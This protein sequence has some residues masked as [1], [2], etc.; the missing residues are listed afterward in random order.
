[1]R[2][3]PGKSG[4][5]GAQQSAHPEP[6]P[7]T[8]YTR[9]KSIPRG[10]H[11]E[12]DGL[13]RRF[14]EEHDIQRRCSNI[15]RTAERYLE[16]VEHPRF[17][18]G[19]R[20]KEVIPTDVELAFYTGRLEKSSP[21]ESH[22]RH[23]LSIGASEMQYDL[24]VDGT[25]LEGESLPL[26]SLQIVNHSCTPNCTTKS[27]ESACTL[28]L[29]ILQ[30]SREI[31][32]GEHVSFNYGG[33]FWCP[34][35][36][37][38]TQKRR[39][40]KLVKCQCANPCPN[41]YARFEKA[42]PSR[43]GEAPT[44]PSQ[45]VNKRSRQ[46]ETSSESASILS[47]FSAISKEPVDIMQ[48][49]GGSMD[50]SW[51][52][53][54]LS[55]TARH[56]A[57]P[58]ESLNPTTDQPGSPP[59]RTTHSPPCPH[60][61]PPQHTHHPQDTL[62]PHPPN[63]ALSRSHQ[64]PPPPPVLNDALPSALAAV[65]TAHIITLNVGPC[66]LA[67]TFASLG[68]IL[69]LRPVAVLVQEAHVPVGRLQAVRRQIHRHFPAYS[70][71]AN[72][73]TQ[74]LSG[75]M[76]VITL[77]HVKMAAR[78]SLLDIR[79]QFQSV[80]EQAPDALDKVHF[81]RLSDPAG[82][83]TILLG[84]VHNYQA[85]Q[86]LRQ[87]AMLELIRQVVAR[88]AP[89]SNHVLIGGDWNATLRTR[90]GYVA[91][92]K[93]EAADARLVAW[94][95]AVGWNYVAPSEHTW[96][97]TSGRKRATLDAFLATD[98]GSLSEATCVETVDPRHDHR[99][100]RVI[101]RDEG[102]GP[103]PEL[104]SLC[105][106]VRLKLTGLRDA[107]IRERFRKR[108]DE[109]VLLV[110]QEAQ[111]GCCAFERL[112]RLQ[113]AV[114]KAAKTT[115][116]TSGGRIR[117]LVPKQSV[118]FRKLAA[119]IRLLRV[120]CAEL[121]R[122][123]E[124]GATPPS[125]AMCKAWHQCQEVYPGGTS[126]Q[127]LGALAANG[128]WSRR[129]VAGLRAHIHNAEEELHQLRRRESR[130]DMAR[131]RQAEID[132]F[133]SGGGLQRFLH[134][135]TPAL[136]S[137][138]LLAT[139]V[140][141]VTVEGEAPRLR[142][143]AEDPQLQ[144]L[145]VRMV[146]ARQDRLVASITSTVQLNALL[147]AVERVQA[148]VTVLDGGPR[149]IADRME[150]IAQWERF[151]GT[152]AGAT[153]QQCRECNSTHLIYVPGLTK[154]GRWWCSECSHFSTPVVEKS[155]YSRIPFDTASIAR[156]PAGATLRGPITRE[157]FDWYL[158]TLRTGR[159][160]G[161]D[162]SPN[163]LLIFGPEVQRQSL[164][165]CINAILAEGK[166][167][168]AEWLGGL[169]R[170][171]PKPGGNPLVSS[172]YRPVCLQAAVYKVLSAIITDRLYRLSE[173]H[174]LLEGSQEGF[175]RKRSTQ[176][177]VQ[178][179]HWA[180][181]EAAQ[182]GASLYVAYLDFEHAFNSVDHEAVWRWLEELNVP[183][184]DLL[185]SLYEGAHYEADLPYGRSAPV[186]LTRGTKQG[187][188]LSPLLFGLF[189]NA[190]LIGL[191]QSGV[192]HRLINGQQTTNRGFADDVALTTATQAGMQKLLDVVS[193]FCSWSGMRLKLEKSV[194]TAFDFGRRQA[195]PTE[196]I[197]YRGSAL[198]SLPPDRSFRYLGVKTALTNGRK[199]RTASGP[200]TA[201]EIQHVQQSTKELTLLLADHN[202]PL[203]VIVPAMR[204]VAASRFRYSAALVPW[205]DAALEKLFKVWMQVERAA[206][207]L[208]RSFPSA[209]FRLP[210]EMGGMPLEDP[211]V[212][213]IQALATHVRQLVALPDSIRD[214]TVKRYR[215]LCTS[216]G[217]LNERELAQYLAKEPDGE[218]RTDP[219]ARLLRACGQLGMHIKLPD[220]LSAGKA[221]REVSWF[222]FRVHLENKITAEDETGQRD[223]RCV[224]YHWSTIRKRFRARGIHFPRQ[225][226]LDPWA[227]TAQ[228][229]IPEQMT[230]QPGWLKPLRRLVLRADV[231]SLFHRLDRG[232]GAPIQAAH[233]ELLSELLRRS[234]G[235]DALQQRQPPA[236][237]SDARWAQVRSSAP[238]ECWVR[239]LERRQI[240]RPAVLAGV[241]RGQAVVKMLTD[242]GREFRR[243]SEVLRAICL[244]VAPT[245]YTVAQGRDM[246]HEED[247]FSAHIPLSRDFVILDSG[248]GRV[249]IEMERQ[250]EEF[251]V[252]T[253]KGV[254]QIE[255]A[256]GGHTATV[257]QGRYRLLAGVYDEIEVI[258]AL[259]GWIAR[260]ER[261]EKTRGV[262]SHQLWH[263]ICR[264][265]K[266]D[267]I[268]GCNPLVAPSCFT[269]ALSGGAEEGWGHRQPQTRRVFNLLCMTAPE[270]MA[271]ASS[272]RREDA[273]LALSRARTLTAEAERSLRRVGAPVHVW[274][275]GTV[276][277]A[278]TG[279]WRRAQVRSIR[280]RE[281]W[282]LWADA[283]TA[284][285]SGSELRQALRNISL[286]SDGAV[287][288]DVDCPSFR[289]AVLG[290]AG[291]S[292]S[293][294][295]TIIATDGAV[296][297][298]G[299]MGAAYVALSNRIPARSFVVLGPPS[300]MRAELSGLDQAIADAPAQE[301]LT[302]LTDSASSIKKLMHMQRRDFAE[303]LYDHP[304]G[305]LLSSIARRV[306]ERAQGRVMTRFVKVPA[307]KA[308]A[309]NEAAD[310][311][312]SAA[313]T[314]AD[315]ETVALCHADCRTVRFYVGEKLTEWGS[316]VRK[317][318]ISVASQQY[319]NQLR[320]SM[321]QQDNNHREESSLTARWLLRPAQG[322]A[323]LGAAMAGMRIGA[324]KRRLMQSIARLF[325][326]RALL[327]RWG[328]A[329]SAECLLCGGA[330]E[331]TAHIQCWCP[332]LK[333]ARIL[334][335]HAIA[336]VI[337]QLLTEHT[338][339]RWQLY[340]ETPVY[341]LRAIATPQDLH[342]MWNRMVDA[343]ESDGSDEDR[344]DEDGQQI[345]RLRP[346]GWAISWSRRQVLI[347]E[348]TRAHDWQEDWHTITDRNKTLRYTR[349]Q[350]LMRASLP[351]GWIVEII[352]LTL[353]IR[354][355][356]DEGRW[357]QILDRFGITK[358]D[359]QRRFM[360]GV[361]RQ[362][363]D[364]LD[365]LYGVRSEALRKLQR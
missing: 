131:Q 144:D 3:R 285:L 348:L 100:V 227:G 111:N 173:R 220:C 267:T 248:V 349:L 167:P 317:A 311:L 358:A 142:L 153:R 216:C 205:S 330:V 350:E 273:W 18:L 256:A 249:E 19:Y 244:W 89:Q 201:D 36:S 292:L 302:L 274:P 278:G 276:A 37:L 233:Q 86:P 146:S 7:I 24:L 223:L 352:T 230:K 64:P 177:Q 326:S 236:L 239:F 178:S 121:L 127:E 103:M 30:S 254:V 123:R 48:Q 237:F 286:S 283:K 69:A 340:A 344:A 313:A 154:P 120:V 335:H 275:K 155:A 202:L 105:K 303:W 75:K 218:F 252:R 136:H 355:S 321:N 61:S 47:Y 357:A 191:R 164:Y 231:R 308:H 307:H 140:D 73:K 219:I 225:L 1:M 172:S 51:Q 342:D 60:S 125:R 174:G 272:V 11:D 186:T 175:R 138:V 141:T 5:T 364:E 203:S 343:L 295:G 195:L 171:L 354:G 347:L 269:V 88:W 361:T 299:S 132:A 74:A 96:E 253:G 224:R 360:G 79:T 238:M 207:K 169:V 188:I 28:E 206:W 222:A 32:K 63:T 229:L 80:C 309:L 212:V 42:Q 290:P 204:M 126:F 15:R 91:G 93:T 46:T 338:A 170:F 45:P 22:R 265:F 119:W 166:A 296:K 129:A 314:E 159:A 57:L 183:D 298:D 213:L 362:V 294:P 315:G 14:H 336:R 365:R 318:L 263:G 148:L 147:T 217:C 261:E 208:Q 161:P 41:D 234:D 97:D 251:T 65:K 9:G 107:E 198:A 180:I 77:V 240:S 271:I 291:E 277:A 2:K 95:Q 245:L 316:R 152:A 165:E 102:V 25:P 259:P 257:N 353:G 156:V 31:R 341:A 190:L 363:L 289:E 297:E 246:E 255:G 53:A 118:A 117:P 137:P 200:C 115:L 4:L 324:Q 40:F 39:G 92:S 356:F 209:Q 151:L 38:I 332:A 113:A 62:I 56:I 67:E 116:G 160:P 139:L 130:E 27:I 163:E 258:R 320:M 13:I 319:A 54:S 76:D 181:E 85:D 94:T 110:A 226:V 84:N 185:R 33:S 322:R 150:R 221:A 149:Y 304:D 68:P 301:D 70:L 310:A 266:A 12:I 359:N 128:E 98:A 346:D 243:H 90:V 228:W 10:D 333:D 189:F 284:A 44:R 162:Q 334:A 168:P 82:Q 23:V 101:L 211:R 122:R 59:P 182:S 287:P 108:A 52:S 339:G 66:G 247:A 351:Q 197:R 71:F 133:W 124:E 158:T 29:T 35:R 20:A 312:A 325:P 328:K 193:D 293:Y 306:N 329:P 50:S 16:E 345:N 135:P 81:L 194:I 280:I 21:A 241:S 49:E 337:F 232:M 6:G 214:A 179:L 264:A 78:A 327:H 300:V 270:I 250:V 323:H 87:A 242:I 99:G 192:G 72:R 176:R 184:V 43:S 268:W 260:V 134:P 305:V 331:S 210:S 199:R 104:E 143:L 8:V 157:D 112:A 114:L 262:P 279:I 187:D 109:E 55:L 282:T 17:G 145:Q 215:R 83:T 281:N 235:T 58:Q 288:L 34:R 106:P 26:G 196:E